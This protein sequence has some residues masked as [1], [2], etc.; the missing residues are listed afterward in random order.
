MKVARTVIG[1]AALAA[2]RAAWRRC[3]SRRLLAGCASLLAGP[4]ERDLRSDALPATRQ[5]RRAARRCSSPSRRRCTRSTPTASPR[6]RP[7]RNTPIC[8]APCGATGCRSSCRRGWCETLQNSGRARAVAVPGQGLL[9]DYQIVLDVR[10][11]EYTSEGAVADFVVRVMDDR[12]GRVVRSR[13]FRY[14]VPVASRGTAAI[15]AGARPGH[16]PGLRRDRQL[17][18]GVRVPSDPSSARAGPFRRSDTVR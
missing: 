18:A 8:R 5:R 2:C 16:G 9:I 10:A 6:A 14:V 12:N 4:A 1:A 11:F 17:G 15:V 3:C 13:G 7:R